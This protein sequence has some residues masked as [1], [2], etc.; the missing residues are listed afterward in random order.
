MPSI[1]TQAIVLRRVNYR[2]NDRM[3]T[4][5]SPTLGRVDAVARGCR[6]TTSA[7]CGATELFCAGEYQFH[8][9]RD[10][11]TLT[12]CAIQESF[13]P[14]REE[15]DRLVYGAYLLALCEA[16]VQPGEEHPELYASLLGALARLAY[17]E[18]QRP[19]AALTVVFLLQFAESLGYRPRLDACAHCGIAVPDGPVARFG[20]LA[21]GI[22]CPACGGA[23]ELIRPDTLCFLRAA[24]RSGFDCAMDMP[25]GIQHEAVRCMRAYLEC[26][27]ERTI[28]AAKLLPG[29]DVR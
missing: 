5:F 21:G 10:R 29:G 22:L 24:Q 6:K 11:Y 3:L 16:S 20:A 17:G 27:V 1:A 2:D 4:L 18:T 19:A 7:L 8:Q 15:Y 13:Y 14:L 25:D 23:A 28:K 9:G 26:R 12:G